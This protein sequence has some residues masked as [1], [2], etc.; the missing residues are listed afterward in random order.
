MLYLLG[1]PVLAMV[2]YIR[3]RRAE[4]ITLESTYRLFALR[5]SLR[6]KAIYGDIDPQDWLFGYLDESISKLV[7]ALP[8][9]NIY[10]CLILFFTHRKQPKFR[11]FRIRVDTELQGKEGLK[12]IYD[13]MGREILRFITARHSNLFS[14]VKFGVISVV[15]PVLVYKQITKTV[16]ESAS[17]VRLYPETSAACFS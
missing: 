1:L 9:L 4:I 5:D 17:E 2:W 15:G 3:Y 7:S 12:D 10:F 6:Q 11:E 13:R 8:K 16:S 14:L